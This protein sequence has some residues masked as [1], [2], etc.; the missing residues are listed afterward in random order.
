[1]I[2]ILLNGAPA[3]AAGTVTDLIADL[4]GRAIGADGIATDG[5]PL[6]IAV[7]VNQAVVPRSRWS[8]AALAA[9][10]EVEVLTAVQGG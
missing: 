6:G 2:D 4:T 3:Q 10:D 9:G 7:A 8:S 1:M 5:S